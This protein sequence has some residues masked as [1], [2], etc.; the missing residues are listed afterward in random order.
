MKEKLPRCKYGNVFVAKTRQ[1]VIYGRQSIKLDWRRFRII[2][3]GGNA[4]V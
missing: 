1:I 4:V 2:Q 3:I